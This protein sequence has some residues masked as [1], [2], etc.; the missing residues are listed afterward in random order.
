M[1]AELIATA[2]PLPQLTRLPPHAKGAVLTLVLLSCG[3]LVIDLYSSAIARCNRCWL[4]SCTS[5]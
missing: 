3:H 1:A 2:E 4:T 5:R